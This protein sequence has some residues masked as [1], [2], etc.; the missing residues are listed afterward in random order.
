MSSMIGCGGVDCCDA[1]DEQ[2]IELSANDA[3]DLIAEKRKED[4]LLEAVKEELS[5]LNCN[6]INEKSQ[7]R[8]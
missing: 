3:D 7:I 2:W 4:R 8:N 5:R 1:R 6:E